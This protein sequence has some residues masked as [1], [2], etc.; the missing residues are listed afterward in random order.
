MTITV[1][2][3]ISGVMASGT[4]PITNASVQLWAAGST[5]YS[6]GATAVGSPVTTNATTGAF[7]IPYDC[8]TLVTPGDQLYLVA[9][10]TQSNVVLM[11]ALGSC[12]TL[13]GSYIVNEATT[14]ASAYALQQ[15]M[16]ADGTI[17]AAGN[18]VSYKGLSNAFKTVS[19]LVDLSAGH[20]ARPH[21]GLLDKPGG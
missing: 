6:M 15:F 2:P 11:S 20:G 1:A 19:N 17:G 3:M 13:S 4:T 9:T 5:G 7:A 21:T 16:A 12:A 8:S 18:S 10:G 14:V